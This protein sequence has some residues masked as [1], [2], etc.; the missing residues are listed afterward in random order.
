M[1]RLSGNAHV[2]VSLFRGVN[3]ASILFLAV[4]EAEPQAFAQQTGLAN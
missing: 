2:Y 1:A 4:T 3:I